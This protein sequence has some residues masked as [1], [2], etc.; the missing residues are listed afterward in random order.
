MSTNTKSYQH[1]LLGL[2]FGHMPIYLYIYFACAFI[3]SHFPLQCHGYR[4]CMLNLP[5]NHPRI[6]LGQLSYNEHM[7]DWNEFLL[8]ASLA[9]YINACAHK[10][11][12]LFLGYPSFCLYSSPSMV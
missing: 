11:S 6:K 9:L 7:K 3:V 8:E 2:Y 1:I 12:G 5:R 10:F 4:V